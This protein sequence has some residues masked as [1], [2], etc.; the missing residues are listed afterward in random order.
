MLAFYD[1]YFKF[2]I[3]ALYYE[4]TIIISFLKSDYDNKFERYINT[5]NY[6]ALNDIFINCVMRDKYPNFFSEFLIKIELLLSYVLECY[7]NLIKLKL[8]TKSRKE[9]TKMASVSKHSNVDNVE[10]QKLIGKSKVIFS[11]IKNK[12]KDIENQINDFGIFTSDTTN[13]NVG[14]VKQPSLKS[15]KLVPELLSKAN[16]KISNLIFS[17]ELCYSMQNLNVMITDYITNI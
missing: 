14:Y 9:N 4:I 1:I 5:N 11:N 12:I 8:L 15:E 2:V 16:K 3:T 10:E 13:S 17:N 6:K 7:S